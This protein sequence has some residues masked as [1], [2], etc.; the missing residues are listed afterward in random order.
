MSITKKRYTGEKRVLRAFDHA[1]FEDRKPTR[2][3]KKPKR[4]KRGTAATRK[5]VD[6]TLGRR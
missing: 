6:K 2:L 1:R 4:A 3:T 5:R